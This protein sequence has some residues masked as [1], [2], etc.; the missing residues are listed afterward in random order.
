MTIPEWVKPGVW[1]AIGGA[2]AA[3][4]IGFVW[5]GW[6]TGGTAGKMETASAETAIVQAFTPLCVTKAEQQPEQLP[7]LK[8][9]SRYKRDDFVIEAGWVNNVSEK[10]RDEVAKACA[11]IVV[12]G[13]TTD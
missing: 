5:G 8:E 9:E 1:G 6:V 2:V 13:M 3:M 11:S 4:I 12:E 7:A 10:Y